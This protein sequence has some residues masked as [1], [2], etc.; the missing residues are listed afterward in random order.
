MIRHSPEAVP[1]ISRT[2][3]VRSLFILLALLLLMAAAR[4]YTYTEPMERD[5]QLYA[6]TAHAMLA[7][8]PLYKDLWVNVPPAIFMTYAFGEKI[9]GVGPFLFYFLW[10]LAVF[11]ILV[12][13]YGAGR[14]GG[15]AGGLWAAVFWA[16]S[17][18]DLMLE[19]NAPNTEIFVNAFQAGA[20]ALAVESRKPISY[21]RCGFIG[22]LAGWA[23]LYKHPGIVFPILLALGMGLAA[24]REGKIKVDLPRM[25]L[26]ILPSFLFWGLTLAYFSSQ[27]GFRDFW[28]AMVTYDNYLAGNIWD[29]LAKGLIP[30]NLWHQEIRWIFWPLLFLALPALW[31]TYRPAPERWNLLA[32]FG[33]AVWIETNASGHRWPHYFQLGL[34]VLMVAG[35][36]GAAWIWQKK[37]TWIWPVLALSIILS[38]EVP[39]YFI[40]PDQWSTERYGTAFLDSQRMGEALNRVLLPGESFYHYGNEIGLY[41]AARRDPPS[42]AFCA[43]FL[44]DGPVAGRLMDRLKRDLAVKKPEVVVVDQV[45]DPGNTAWFKGDYEAWK[46]YPEDGRFLVMVRKGGELEK[47]IQKDPWLSLEPG[48]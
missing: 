27:G 18:T 46:Y 14:F 19:A 2:L 45:N 29:N 34:P 47:R 5:L 20:F 30:G 42:G 33:V 9:A 32:A 31:K 13:V 15:Q 21:T 7:G 16:V 25:A 8:R 1:E 35:G 37:K 17:C 6:V 41:F 11:G 10:L 48:P 24:F 23:A 44:T 28:D 43:W 26:V 39:N 38:H 36:W 4:F 22:L 3:P 12:G 40:P